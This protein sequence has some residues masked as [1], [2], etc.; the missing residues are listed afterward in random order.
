MTEKEVLELME[1]SR[2]GKEWN[3]NCDKVKAAFGG[4]PDFWFRLIL[5]SG[6]ATRIVATWTN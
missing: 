6:V 4:Y 2:H 3:A 1:S 5:A